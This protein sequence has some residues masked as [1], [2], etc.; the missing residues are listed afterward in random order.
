MELSES[1]GDCERAG[2]Y[3]LQLAPAEL[4]NH[5]ADTSCESAIKDSFSVPELMLMGGYSE[6]EVP[7]GMQSLVGNTLQLEFAC[8]AQR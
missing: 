7:D 4:S 5:A 3:S 1:G 2:T 8:P 6:G